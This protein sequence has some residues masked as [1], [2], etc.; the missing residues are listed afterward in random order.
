MMGSM[1]F[2]F[3]VVATNPDDTVYYI[4]VN[5]ESLFKAAELGL[6]LLREHHPDAEFVSLVVLF[7]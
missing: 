2:D 3:S 1:T 7:G 5:A 6:K 4:E